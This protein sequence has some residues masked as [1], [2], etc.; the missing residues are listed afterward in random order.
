MAR[1]EREGP[2]GDDLLNRR[3]AA[4]GIAA[5]A[6]LNAKRGH[7][8][9]TPQSIGKIDSMPGIGMA[10]EGSDPQNGARRIW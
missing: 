4:A 10:S 3:V 6:R 7:R 1:A 2:V 5:Q 8:E 9:M